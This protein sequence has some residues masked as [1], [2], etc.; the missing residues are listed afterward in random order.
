MGLMFDLERR[1][2][3]HDCGYVIPIVD[4]I[5]RHGEFT[6][7]PE[8]TV[9]VGMFMPPDGLYLSIDFRDLTENDVIV[10]AEM[11]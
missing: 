1:T 10:A 6:D 3:T 11:N 9:I 8:E 4:M 2:A 5:D 7:S